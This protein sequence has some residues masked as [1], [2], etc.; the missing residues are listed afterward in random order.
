MQRTVGVEEE[1]LL[2]DPDDGR[3]M[4]VGGVVLTVDGDDELTGELQREQV[5]TGTSPCHGLGEL[6]GELR[7]TRERARA[8]ANS[9]GA[10]LAPLATSPLPV[11]PTVSPGARYRRMVERFGLTASE[12]LT[13]GCHVHVAISSAAE[14]PRSIASDPGSRRCWHCRRTP[15]SGP[16]PTPVTPATAARSGVAGPRPGPPSCSATRPATGRLLR[17]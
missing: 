12:Q 14:G 11:R 17:R 13:C 3:A 2:V 5:E 8:A 6:G 16:T 1:F 7:R 10:A 15:R 4:A 9:A